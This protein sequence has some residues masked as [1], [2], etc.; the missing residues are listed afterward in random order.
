MSKQLSDYITSYKPKFAESVAALKKFEERIKS[1]KTV[2]AGSSKKESKKRFTT[3]Q[4]IV[5]EKVLKLA[6]KKL[7]EAGETPISDTVEDLEGIIIDNIKSSGVNSPVV[8]IL[9]NAA[10]D[11]KSQSGLQAQLESMIREAEDTETDEVPVEEAAEDTEADEQMEADEDTSPAEDVPEDT[12]GEADEDSETDEV[13]SEEDTDE[14]DAN[15]VVEDDETDMDDVSE[16]EDEPTEEADEDEVDEDTI[17]EAE[18]D[19]MDTFDDTEGKPAVQED[20]DEVD[21]D[22]EMQ[23]FEED[24]AAALEKANADEEGANGIGKGS[25][26][27]GVKASNDA[28]GT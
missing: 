5:L 21:E 3:K 24:I 6:N 12:M 19:G 9:T 11:L 2:K 26:V 13:V 14:D 27:D 23:E 17:V 16:F 4:R 7:R 10:R 20:E 8:D 28:K 15:E 1:G 25:K 22:T 18:D